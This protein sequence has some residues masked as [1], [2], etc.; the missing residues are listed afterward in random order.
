M[1][2]R[3]RFMEFENYELVSLDAIGQPSEKYYWDSYTYAH[4]GL[5]FSD[6]NQWYEQLKISFKTNEADV[7]IV[8]QKCFRW[9]ETT[10]QSSFWR[11]VAR[12]F[13]STPEDIVE[14]EET[15]N[16]VLL[17]NSDVLEGSVI[18]IKGVQTSEFLKNYFEVNSLDSPVKKV[19]K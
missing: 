12:K 2:L 16:K 8:L 10:E 18:R 13:E 1:G 4:W 6:P 9:G 17:F 11:I 19:Q 7:L 15:K 5:P 3:S 14:I